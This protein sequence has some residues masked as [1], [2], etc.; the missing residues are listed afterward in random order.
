MNSENQIDLKRFIPKKASKF[1]VLKIAFYA[2]MITVLTFLL[3]RQMGATKKQTASIKTIK[4][5]TISQ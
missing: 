3:I 2:V 4:G 5:V 1:Y